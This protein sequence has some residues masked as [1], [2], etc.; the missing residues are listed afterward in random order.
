MNLEH[1]F[2]RMK[3]GSKG[4]YIE[5][6][7]AMRPDQNN[8]E[9]KGRTFADAYENG[10]Y[11]VGFMTGWG[12]EV[13][14]VDTKVRP[15]GTV[16]PG[17]ASWEILKAKYNLPETY[18][19]RTQSGGTHYYY[20]V[21]ED[22]EL[23]NTMS[24]F[25]GKGIDSRG[26]VGM[27][28]FPPSSV[29]TPDG[30]IREYT[31]I[32][33]I[34]IVAMPAEMLRDRFAYR[35]EIRAVFESVG[36]TFDK[37]D[38]LIVAGTRDGALISA[39][40]RLV[41]ILPYPTVEGIVPQIR[42]LYFEYCEEPTIEGWSNMEEKLPSKI[43][44][45]IAERKVEQVARAEARKV[46]NV[47]INTTSILDDYINKRRE[48]VQ[49]PTGLSFI[50]DQ[51]NGGP[52][53]DDLFLIASR[54]KSGKTS[55]LIDLCYRWARAEK[56]IMFLE[57]EMGTDEI[58]DRF[59][60]RHTGISSWNIAKQ[61]QEAIDEARASRDILNPIMSN[62]DLVIEPTARIT[63]Q[64]ITD[65]VARREAAVGH[66]FDIIAVDYV[67]LLKGDGENYWEQCL[68]VATSLRAYTLSHKRMI[69][70]AVQLNREKEGVDLFASMAGGDGWARAHTISLFLRKEKEKV[71]I[72]KKDGYPDKDKFGN[73]KFGETDEDAQSVVA[74]GGKTMES[75][76]LE[77]TIAGR[78]V[79]SKKSSQ[80][81]AFSVCAFTDDTVPVQHPMGANFN[82]GVR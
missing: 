4:T 73:N 67:G 51:C 23:I 18:T 45:W 15:D 46:G 12:I 74:V 65:L 64:S 31:I 8:G 61:T 68:D 56:K 75:N 60:A 47:T 30:E 33:H 49:F 72:M 58:T 57:M 48:F 14:D 10:S 52:R 17:A 79:I 6:W 1:R 36:L 27:A 53:G 81:F 54:M 16:A 38:N 28:V 40:G 5:G 22:A 37:K 80:P 2:F 41:K 35:K 70:A 59:L 13:I 42:Q 11:N 26:H 24:T 63:V 19:V 66:K 77:V 82:G 29:V 69:I 55:V 9:W 71:Q 43:A 76:V 32:N 62:I 34:P 7:K 78:S 39:A 25:Y 50:D 3:K 20:S 44:N 21:P